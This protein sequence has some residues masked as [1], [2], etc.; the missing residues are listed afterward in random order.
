[1]LVLL[2]VVAIALLVVGQAKRRSGAYYPGDERYDRY[3]DDYQDNQWQHPQ[4]S[5]PPQHPYYPSQ[6]P[7]PSQIPYDPYQE[8]RELQRRLY[9]ERL[10]YRRNVGVVLAIVIGL[11]LFAMYLKYEFK[12]ESPDPKEYPPDLELELDDGNEP[13]AEIL[14]YPSTSTDPGYETPLYKNIPNEPEDSDA[15]NGEEWNTLP[16]YLQAGSFKQIENANRCM[17]ECQELGLRCEKRT[18]DGFHRV[19]VGPF[20][21][22]EEAGQLKID[23]GESGWMVVRLE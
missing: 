14:E 16:V 3:P 9:F 21:T 4:S 13:K 23:L 10:E 20:D 12:D 6:Y 5:Y 8:Q 7:Y 1:M 22:V 19:F 11:G 2:A 15:Y 17:A 18:V